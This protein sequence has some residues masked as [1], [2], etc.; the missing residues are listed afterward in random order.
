MQYELIPVIIPT[1]AITGVNVFLVILPSAP[2]KAI[3]IIT[4]ESIQKPSPIYEKIDSIL[5]DN[6]NLN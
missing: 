3:M 2:R 5:L 1:I 6:I 4:T